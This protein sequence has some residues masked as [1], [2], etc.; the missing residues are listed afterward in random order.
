[1]QVAEISGLTYSLSGKTGPKTYTVRAVGTS[2]TSSASNAVTFPAS[3]STPSA[4]VLQLK[5]P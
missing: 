4:P 1:V 3:T 5:Q 2:G